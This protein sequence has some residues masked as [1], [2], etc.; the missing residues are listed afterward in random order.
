MKYDIF[1]PWAQPVPDAPFPLT[2]EY[3][4]AVPDDGWQYEIVEGSPVRIP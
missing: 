4:L 1:T 3:L 2:A